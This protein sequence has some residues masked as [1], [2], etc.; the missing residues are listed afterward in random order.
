[1]GGECLY[2]LISGDFEVHG[3][4][5]LNESASLVGSDRRGLSGL[6]STILN[7]IECDLDRGDRRSCGDG[8]TII[9]GE[10]N[11]VLGK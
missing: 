11:Y 9:D 2:Q 8:A 4:V 1:M 3:D 5:G 7:S 10:V 6:N